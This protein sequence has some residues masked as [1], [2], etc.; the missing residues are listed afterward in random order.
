MKKHSILLLGLF[1]SIIACTTI[2]TTKVN[3]DSDSDNKGKH[4]Y[5]A[6]PKTF[7]KIDVELEKTTYERGKYYDY[8]VC[9]KIISPI[10]RWT[11]NSDTVKTIFKV[12][13]TKISTISKLDSDNIYQS[14]IVDGFLNKNDFNFN[15]NENG[16]LTSAKLKSENQSL[17]F[18]AS[19][20]KFATGLATGS[21]SLS[22]NGSG[23]GFLKSSCINNLSANDTIKIKQLLTRI[24][25]L[26][27]SLDIT[28]TYKDY[29]KVEIIKYQAGELEKEKKE[30]VGKYFTQKAET[31]NTTITLLVNP[32]DIKKDFEVKPG[33]T[34]NPNKTLLEF[35]GNGKVIDKG[36]LTKVLFDRKNF[37]N[38]NSSAKS[39]KN[40]TID[41]ITDSDYSSALKTVNGNG[42]KSFY[43]RIPSYNKVLIY[44]N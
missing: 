19:T 28:K 30:I 42:E 26:N 13:S 23:D 7:L 37:A 2:K 24:Q 41:L 32:D 38:T 10:K 14:K 44:K 27:S 3:S 6:L 12:K 17:K 34:I 35:D 20:I 36:N 11:A 8:A 33:L 15:Y 21:A 4:F 16:E 22:G 1:F 25:E 29:M 18:A 39:S 5:Y 40:L 31:K 9:A 43:Y